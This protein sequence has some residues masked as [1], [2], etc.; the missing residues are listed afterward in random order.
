MFVRHPRTAST[1]VDDRQAPADVGHWKIPNGL[2]HGDVVITR[3]PGEP[4]PRYTVRQFDGVPQLSCDS[5]EKAL[6]A[7]RSFAQLHKV[8]IWENNRGTYT[9]VAPRGHGGR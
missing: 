4:R 8:G 2:R 5:L 3:E 9:S 1:S 7:A 6:K